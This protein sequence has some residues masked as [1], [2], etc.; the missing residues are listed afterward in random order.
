MA[1]LIYVN[2][3]GSNRERSFS[4]VRNY[5]YQVMQALS[6]RGYASVEGGTL[7]GDSSW[8]GES[9]GYVVHAK[10]AEGGKAV[11]FM[12]QTEETVKKIIEAVQLSIPGINLE[13]P[14]KISAPE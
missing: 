5:H 7:D 11:F 9:G 2:T 1:G 14:V 13:E 8:L 10:L 12:A 3:F 4:T 6:E